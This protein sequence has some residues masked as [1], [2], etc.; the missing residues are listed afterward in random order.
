MMMMMMMMMIIIM[1]IIIIITIITTT[2][3]TTTTLVAQIANTGLLHHYEYI[4]RKRGLF[5]VYNCK[6]PA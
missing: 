1:I 3:T 6:Y 5:Q 2:T 4:P